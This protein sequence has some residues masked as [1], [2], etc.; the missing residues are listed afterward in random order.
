MIRRLRALGRILRAR[1]RRSRDCR[2]PEDSITSRAGLA[3][4]SSCRSEF[5]FSDSNLMHFTF[6]WCAFSKRISAMQQSFSRSS[7]VPSGFVGSAYQDGDRAIITQRFRSVSVVRR[8]LPAV[9]SHYRR[10]CD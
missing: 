8:G 7:P 1:P 6:A 2:P 3:S 5:K 10:P 4:Q 9:R